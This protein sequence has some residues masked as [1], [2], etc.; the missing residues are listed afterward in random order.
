MDTFDTTLS[1]D[2]VFEQAVE[3]TPPTDWWYFN[4]KIDAPGT[5]LH[6]AMVIGVWLRFKGFIEEGRF[7]IVH[8]TDHAL[9]GQFGTGPMPVGSIH[10]DTDRLNV[11]LGESHLRGGYPD[12]EVKFGGEPW[13]GGRRIDVELSF[14]AE[15][16]PDRVAWLDRQLNHF[17]VYRHEARGTV[18]I[19]DDSYDVSGNGYYE[20]A[21]GDLGWA[22]PTG[23]KHV[24]TGWNWYWT[25]GGGPDNVTVQMAGI[26]TAADPT[27]WALVSFTT[28]GK[29]YHHFPHV[30]VETLEEREYKGLKYAHR[31]RVTGKTEQ[32][33]VELFVD[34]TSA[35]YQALTGEPGRPAMF[36]R[37]GHCKLAGTISWDG[38]EWDVTT[39]NAF[40]SAFRVIPEGQAD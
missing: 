22:D 36:F 38:E 19:G 10:A 34:R 31:L 24:A 14:H 18:T 15:Q 29:S 8:P 16:E 6:G 35:E 5:P 12:Y 4:T 11:E 37:T 13:D 39:D 3:P 27:A 20:H 26:T 17:V 21:Y 25:P 28:D 30:L 23:V 32:G 40:G 7:Q 33:Q 2:E 1:P 9:I